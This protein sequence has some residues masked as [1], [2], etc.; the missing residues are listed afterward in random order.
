MAV[1]V[2]SPLCQWFRVTGYDG[3]LDVDCD[4]DQEAHDSELED[5]VHGKS[6]CAR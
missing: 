1:P 2:I 3:I 4:D 5:A 6:R